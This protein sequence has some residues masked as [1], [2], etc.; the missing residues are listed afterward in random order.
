MGSGGFGD[1]FKV[2]FPSTCNSEPQVRRHGS[3]QTSALKIMENRERQKGELRLVRKHLIDDIHGARKHPNIV[4]I[5]DAFEI[6]KSKT[7]RSY[8]AIHMELCVD[9]LDHFLRDRR[10]ANPA[11]PLEA[12]QI[13][14]IL[15]QILSGLRYCHEMGFAH[16][17][18]KPANGSPPLPDRV[19]TTKYY[20]RGKNVMNTPT[21]PKNASSSQTSAYPVRP[22]TKKMG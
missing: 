10:N 8:L 16:R 11:E 1:V 9:N 6:E 19:L 12:T 14:C 4:R 13:Y 21:N 3:N 5:M 18:L 20:T 17:D 7:E 2:L 15:I 22:T